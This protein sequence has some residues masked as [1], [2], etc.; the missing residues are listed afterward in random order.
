VKFADAEPEIKG[1]W[2]RKGRLTPH[3]KG[4]RRAKGYEREMTTSRWKYDH[5]ILFK[6]ARCSEVI[7]DIDRSQA[8]GLD[9]RIGPRS[10]SKKFKFPDC[11]T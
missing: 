4:V 11:H 3:I 7:D 2:K 10:Y 6:S 5:N 8:R 9:V 1:W